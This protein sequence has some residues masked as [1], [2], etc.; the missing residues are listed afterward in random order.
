MNEVNRQK[1]QHMPN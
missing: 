1:I